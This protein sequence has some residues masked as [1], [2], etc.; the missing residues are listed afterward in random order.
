M[1]RRLVVMLG[2]TVVV[3][4]M[5]AGGF[6]YWLLAGSGVRLAL[7]RQASAWLGVPVHIGLAGARLFPEPGLHLE[8]VEIGEPV[9]LTLGTVDVSA[10]GQALLSRRIEQA[11]LT[12]TNSRIAMPLPFSWP[13]AATNADGSDPLRL[14]SIRSIA[15]RDVV[16][17]SRGR[18]LT[19]SA[20]SALNGTRLLLRSFSARTGGTSL[21]A[22]GEV[23]LAPRIDAR[24][25]VKANRLDVDELIAL[26]GAFAPSAGR[27]AGT[28]SRLAPRLAAR[29]TAETARAGDVTVRQFASDLEVDGT[30]LSLSPLTFQLFGGRYQGALV[31]T[32]GDTVMASLRS[33]FI[34]L[35]AAQVADFGN[36]PGAITGA[37]TGAGTFSGSGRDV[38]SILAGAGGQGTASIVNGSIR[39]LDLVRTVVLFFGRPAPDAGPSSD[40]FERLD[41]AFT[42]ARG[43]VTAQALSLHSD[44]ADIVGGGTLALDDKTLNGRID[45]SLSEAL[46]RQAGTDLARYTREDNRIVL[47]ATVGGTLSGPRINIDAAAAAQRGLRNELQRR[48]GDLL[49]QFKRAQQPAAP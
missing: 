13:A 20:D 19:V 22:L 4:G 29:V 41:A 45:I 15:L 49:D 9:Q 36:S 2:I 6:L 33:R 34:D 16:I 23:D 1:I 25:K 31:A 10:N 40:K 28:G 3:A 11:S 7:E 43:V 46:T 18:E 38:G 44:D 21:E 35:D 5:I 24:L 42:L 12:I 30:R 47:P 26:A 39:H 14:V 37:L 17:T 27:S 32:L 8:R 48:L